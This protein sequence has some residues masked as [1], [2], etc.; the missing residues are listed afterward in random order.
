MP[1]PKI[2]AGIGRFQDQF[3]RNREL[4]ERLATQG[5]APEVQT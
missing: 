3:Q 4:F 5:Q 1:T 2:L